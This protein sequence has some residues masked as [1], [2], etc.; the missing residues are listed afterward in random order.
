MGKLGKDDID[1]RGLYDRIL[2]FVGV[3]FCL[4]VLITILLRVF[5]FVGFY[6]I[7][8][9]SMAP[10]LNPGDNIV[11]EAFSSHSKSVRRGDVRSFSTEG[12]KGIY[13]EK[14]QMYIFRVVGL[15]GD[16]LVIR[17]KKLWVNGKP[18][19][20]V[21]ESPVL[22]YINPG[23]TGIYALTAPYTVPDH[24][25]FV[26]GDNTSNSSDSRVW[27][28]LPKENLRHLYWMHSHRAKTSSSKP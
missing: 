7:P 8:T 6:Q 19:A 1:M 4:L 11:V 27:G 12:I 13:S 21:F 26:I 2:I 9:S 14:P 22:E 15:P 18:Q 24:H 10:F 23:F 16:E 5:G 20:Q 3:G 28:P 17:D 25:Y